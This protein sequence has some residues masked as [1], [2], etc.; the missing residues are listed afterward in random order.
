MEE[1]IV[2]VEDENGEGKGGGEIGGNMREGSEGGVKARGG[3]NRG[4]GKHGELNGHME[5]WRS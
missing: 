1:D 3:V 2:E 5:G 4:R